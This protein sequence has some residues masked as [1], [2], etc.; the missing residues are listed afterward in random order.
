M[1]SVTDVLGSIDT[2]VLDQLGSMRKEE[3]QL[4][5]F[6]ARAKEMKGKVA[7][8]VYR[9][10]LDDYT[11]RAAAL[12]QQATPLRS[13]ARV[14]YRK[15]HQLVADVRR[16]QDQAKLEKEELEF[17]HAVG[18]LDEAQ[19]AAR[20]EEPQGRL[21]QCAADLARIDACTT[22]FVEA[23]G[24]RDAL[25]ATQPAFAPVGAHDVPD[26][27]PTSDIPPID[28]APV[29]IDPTVDESER[30]TV[31]VP[32]A[33][34]LTEP[35]AMPQREYRLGAVN[36]LGRAEDNQVQIMSPEVSR[37]HAVITAVGTGFELKDL[38]S[39]N[40]VNVNG[41]RTA[42]RRLM[43]GDK[44]EIAGVSLVFRMPWPAQSA[45]SAAAASRPSAAKR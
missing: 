41:V 9:R 20:L 36:Y 3:A 39:Q 22:R 25:E 43:D 13:K 16:A 31:L 21:N 1:S 23:F 45:K 10:V 38:G 30:Q 19:L 24:S 15:L 4:E 34:L 40:G 11:K 35:G 42:I 29:V 18:E 28:D 5:A 2:S 33:A 14:E 27:D 17:R 7:D 32:L 12:D 8:Q 26:L 6:C 37:K 44:V